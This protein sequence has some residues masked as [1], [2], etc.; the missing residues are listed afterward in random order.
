MDN[1][2][3]FVRYEDACEFIENVE[4]PITRNLLN[5][6]FVKV[7]RRTSSGNRPKPGF[8]IL[9]CFE[10]LADL[11]AEHDVIRRTLDGERVGALFGDE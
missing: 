7:V 9:F 10:T 3:V 5:M 1:Q 11:F 8:D 2:P 4:D 6:A